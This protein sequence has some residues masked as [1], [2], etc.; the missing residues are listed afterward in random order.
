MSILFAISNLIWAEHYTQTELAY[1]ISV[2]E[3]MERR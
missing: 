3:L 2:R 1:V